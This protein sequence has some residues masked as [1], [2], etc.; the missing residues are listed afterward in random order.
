AAG[1]KRADQLDRPGRLPVFRER[2]RDQG[3]RQADQGCGYGQDAS[4]SVLRSFFGCC[5]YNAAEMASP[6][7]VVVAVPPR[8]LVRC[9]ASAITFVT[10]FCISTAARLALASLCLRP[11]QPISICPD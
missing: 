8:S 9:L 7:C 5:H 6:I 3:A 1:R 4:H 2:G 10:A 11:S